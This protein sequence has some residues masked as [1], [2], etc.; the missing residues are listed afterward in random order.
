MHLERCLR[1]VPHDEDTGGFFVATLRKIAVKAPSSDKASS[2]SSVAAAS[3]S[4]ATASGK[5]TTITNVPPLPSLSLLLPCQYT[6]LIHYQFNVVTEQFT[7][8]HHRHHHHHHHHHNITIIITLT[9]PLFL[10]ITAEQ[11][12]SKSE[13]DPNDELPSDDQ[14]LSLVVNEEGG[15]GDDEVKKGGQQGQEQAQT[16]YNFQKGT[17]N[18]KPFNLKSYEKIRDFYGFSDALPQ[19]A[20]FVREDHMAAKGRQPAHR[21]VIY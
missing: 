11:A 13:A 16:G 1:C 10:I 8:S 5:C 9:T 2:S 12:N 21:C 19:E 18:Y 4:S 7:S 3:S 20:F 15:E 17:V 6:L 14:A